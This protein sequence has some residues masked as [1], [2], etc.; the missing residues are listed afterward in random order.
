MRK[1]PTMQRRCHGHGPWSRYLNLLNHLPIIFNDLLDHLIL[2]VVENPRVQIMLNFVH[3]DRVLLACNEMET[4]SSIVVELDAIRCKKRKP[5]L[6][7]DVKFSPIVLSYPL[8]FYVKFDKAQKRTALLFTLITHSI[9]GH[10][11]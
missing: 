2:T 8:L 3:Q 11:A 10:G 7:V 6:V 5:A 4:E 9:P 1:E